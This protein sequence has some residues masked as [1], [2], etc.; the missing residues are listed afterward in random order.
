[1]VLALEQSLHGASPTPGFRI[2]ELLERDEAAVSLVAS[3]IHGAH[4]ADAELTQDDVATRD[5]LGD[6]RRR[7]H[8]GCGIHVRG[9]PRVYLCVFE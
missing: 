8:G 2:A 5:A 6:G 7:G 4:S 9:F 1:V 3:A